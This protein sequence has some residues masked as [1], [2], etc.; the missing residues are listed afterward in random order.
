MTPSRSFHQRPD[1]LSSVVF[2][3]ILCVLF[4]VMFAICVVKCN[5]MCHGVIYFDVSSYY[6]IMFVISPCLVVFSHCPF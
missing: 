2:V 6:C 3:L 1:V 4:V 5:V